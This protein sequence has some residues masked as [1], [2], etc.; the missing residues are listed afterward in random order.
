MFSLSGFLQVRK[1]DRSLL[2]RFYAIYLVSGLLNTMLGVL[3]PYLGEEYGLAYSVRGLLLSSVQVGNVTAMFL[4]GVLPYVI[5]RKKNTVL[6]ASLMVLGY[7]LMLLVGHP[8]ILFVAFLFTGLGR[9]TLVNISN[10]VVGETAGNKGGGLNLLHACFALGA[11]IAPLLLIATVSKGWRLAPALAL[12]LMVIGVLLIAFSTLSSKPSRREKGKGFVPRTLDFYLDMGILFTYVA[13][14]AGLVG[15]LVTYF[16]DSGLLPEAFS[17][18]MQS[19]LWVMILAGRLSCAF[20]S[21]RMSKNLLLLLCGILMT[22]SFLLMIL[23]SQV[24]LIVLGVLGLGLFMGGI[25]PTTIATVPERYSSDT[26]VMGLLLGSATIGAILMPS[27]IGKLAEA[28]GIAG[29]I[30]SLLAVCLLMIVLMTVKTV[31]KS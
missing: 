30:A 3:M 31:T 28:I 7:L 21:P 27:V 24:P 4:A 19:L 10:V 17:A 16:R 29:G 25:Y 1:S 5:G 6:F 22:L 14:E 15:W 18:S 20:L 12:S 8:A 26:T 13:A 9:G 23:P 2:Y 11:F